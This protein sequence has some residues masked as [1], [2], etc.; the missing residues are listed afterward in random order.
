MPSSQLTRQKLEKFIADS[1]RLE[2]VRHAGNGSRLISQDIFK[3]QKHPD[4]IT[5]QGGETRFDSAYRCLTSYSGHHVATAGCGLL[6]MELHSL[7]N[8]QNVTQ[9][10]F[11]VT[12]FFAA[13]T[14]RAFPTRPPA[15][16]LS[17]EP[18]ARPPFYPTIELI[19]TPPV[20]TPR[21]AQNKNLRIAHLHC[22]SRRTPLLR[23]P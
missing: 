18:S 3:S 15:A 14:I 13:F 22:M 8:Y 1:A 4:H 2:S 11:C 9:N 20:P 5:Y 7:M 19:P 23:T 16:P 21:S 12:D 6:P 17:L 10:L